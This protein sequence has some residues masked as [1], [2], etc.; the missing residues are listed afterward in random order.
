M[1]D[2]SRMQCIA[3]MRRLSF[4]SGEKIIKMGHVGDTIYLISTG[5][6]RPMLDGQ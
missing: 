4:Q 5:K 2:G 6:A 3:R 1:S